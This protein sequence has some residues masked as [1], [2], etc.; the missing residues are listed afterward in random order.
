MKNPY[1][2]PYPQYN[3][4]TINKLKSFDKHLY[5]DMVQKIFIRNDMV[6]IT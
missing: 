6:H 1:V 3:K 4:V 2:L 5:L